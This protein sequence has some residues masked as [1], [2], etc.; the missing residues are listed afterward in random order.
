[1]ETR[2]ERNARLRANCNK[3]EKTP[4]GYLMRSYRNMKSRIEGVQ[5]AKFYLYEGLSIMPKDEFYEYLEDPEFKQLFEEYE[6]SG[7][8]I[9]LAPSPDRVDSLKGYSKENIEWVT[10]SM[11]SRRGAESRWGLV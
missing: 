5:S 1:M 6:N 9:K 10:H 4:K 11:N 8:D 2:R 7:Y 3:Y